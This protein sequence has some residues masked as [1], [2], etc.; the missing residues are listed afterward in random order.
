MRYI[1]LAI[2]LGVLIGYQGWN[3]G[4]GNP[5]EQQIADGL[6]AAFDFLHGREYRQKW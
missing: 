4:E 1:F 5:L 6:A 2:G 3:S